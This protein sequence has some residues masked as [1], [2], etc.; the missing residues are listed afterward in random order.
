MRFEYEE[1]SGM[2]YRPIK[3]RMVPESSRSGIVNGLKSSKYGEVNR[4]LVCCCS[5]VVEFGKKLRTPCYFKRKEDE[6]CYYFLEELSGGVFITRLCR[7][8][9]ILRDS[10]D[11]I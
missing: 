2:N 1:M 5:G 10:F 9:N 6:G 8:P 7:S 3:T 11:A 4:Y